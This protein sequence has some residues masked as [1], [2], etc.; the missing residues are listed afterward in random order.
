[1]ADSDSG[2]EFSL[3]S[4]DEMPVQSTAVD[5][6]DDVPAQDA[7]DCD[8]AHYQGLEG[9]ERYQ[10]DAHVMRIGRYQSSADKKALEASRRDMHAVFPLTEALWR[11]WITDCRQKVVDGDDRLS[12]DTAS[13]YRTAVGDYQYVDLWKEWLEYMIEPEHERMEEI[14]AGKAQPCTVSGVQRN[15]K[16]LRVCFAEAIAATQYHVTKSHLVWDVIASYEEAYM[17]TFPTGENFARLKQLYMERLAICHAAIEDTFSRFSPLV[18]QYCNQQYEAIMVEANTVK[19]A[20]ERALAARE[21]FEARLTFSSNARGA[22]SAYISF[23]KRQR[24]VNHDVVRTLYE[25]ALVIHC[26][27]AALW[28]EYLL[29]TISQTA[30]SPFEIK[31]LCLRAVRNCPWSGDLWGHFMRATETHSYETW[32]PEDVYKYAM[33]FGAVE[34]SVDELAKLF[35]AKG[36]YEIRRYQREPNAPSSQ[37]HLR[38][39]LDQLISI[40]QTKFPDGDTQFRLHKFAAEAHAAVLK[41]IESARKYWEEPLKKRS[42]EAEIWLEY[43]LFERLYGTLEKVQAVFKQACFRVGDWPDR[44]FAAWISFEQQHGTADSINLAY[45]R[46]RHQASVLASRLDAA[47]AEA[48]A[49]ATVEEEQRQ[50]KQAKQQAAKALK[51]DIQK[52]EKMEKRKQQEAVQDETQERETKRARQ[53]EPKST[54]TSATGK[55][56]K[57]ACSILVS[58]LPASIT[59]EAIVEHFSQTGEIKNVL[60]VRDQD[61]S[62]KDYAYVEFAEPTAAEKALSGGDTAILGGETVHMHRVSRDEDPKTLYVCNFSKQMTEARL[63][64]VFSPHGKIVSIRMP[65]ARSDRARQ[66]AYVEFAE[67]AFAR[68]ALALNGQPVEEHR[69]LS[70]AISNPSRKKARS[71]TRRTRLERDARVLFV[72]NFPRTA[73]KEELV[74]LFGQYGYLKDVRILK[75]AH[76]Q[77]K[78]CGFVEF[79]AEAS[80][81][82]A[83]AL[84]DYKMGDR[85]LSVVTADP[86]KR[87]NAGRG[88]RPLAE[89]DTLQRVLRVTRLPEHVTEETLRKSFAEY[90]EVVKVKLFGGGGAIV[91]Y[92]DAQDANRAV[93]GMHDRE[94][95]GQRISVVSA[96]RSALDVSGATASLSA[97]TT[98]TSVTHGDTST[99]ASFAV[100]TA[101]MP[102]RVQRRVVASTGGRPRP[103]L[104][105]HAA[106]AST[107][108]D[109]P[110]KVAGTTMSV[111]VSDTTGDALQSND[112]FR[113]LFLASRQP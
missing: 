76:G 63:R 12:D 23:E 109:T 1:M 107:S 68:A 16:R 69:P 15:A 61:G 104:A 86:D 90:G 35:V 38:L 43:I 62:R 102:R 74:A 42:A 3:M 72:A 91:K 84:N 49:L 70:V 25:R 46:T 78:G 32:T 29:Y 75:D 27:D 88:T 47:E 44:I 58:Q 64:E 51:K 54:D 57:K 6:E 40:L 97:A 65:A 10:Y 93:L 106:A 4:E 110:A 26:L 89:D 112:D 17:K 67:E 87:A 113:K 11:E 99:P 24:P 13:L 55:R 7:T 80:A 77:S 56:D 28:E 52:K 53:D 59:E 20:S 100:P 22:F 31:A 105:K 60:V 94:L 30:P 36:S 111:A 82:A 37:S 79:Y 66:F 48:Q 108:A 45:A 21:P 81:R 8:D 95:D 98:T 50:R 92:G 9:K 101:L 33:D 96:Q 83:L 5:E 41:D 2:S 14:Q 85:H 71:P 34:A 73:E 39:A 18:T 19:Q 103:R